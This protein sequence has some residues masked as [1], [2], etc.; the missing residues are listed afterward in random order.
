MVVVYMMQ[1]LDFVART[2]LLCQGE[3]SRQTEAPTYK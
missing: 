2:Y 1:D 3:S